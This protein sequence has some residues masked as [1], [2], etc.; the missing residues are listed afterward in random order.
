MSEKGKPLMNKTTLDMSQPQE[1]FT[2]A[3]A[4]ASMERLEM[5]RLLGSRSM[6]VKEMAKELNLPMSSAA[7]HLSILEEAGLIVSMMQPGS[8]GNVKLCS[9]CVRTLKIFFTPQGSDLQQ[10]QR[11][12]TYTLP[13]GAF[14]SV[15]D[16]TPTCG[17]G[18]KTGIIAEYDKPSLFYHPK[19]LAAQLMWFRSGFAE[20][21]FPL[22]DQGR[23]KIC[24]L[25][26]SFEANPQTASYHAPWKSDISVS[27]NGVELGTWQAE[28]DR[29]VRR[30]FLTPS[31]WA[32]INTQYGQLKT[33]RVNPNGA[34]LDSMQ[35]SGVTLEQLRLGESDAI[36]IRIGVDSHA[37]NVGG[38]VLF[39]EEAGDFPQGIT[40][41]I[42]Y[43]ALEE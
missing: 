8:R 34:F 6:N 17:M 5:L 16:I 26:L 40:L 33:W 31:W 24:W 37:E 7:M 12:E 29:S 42:G 39:G 32:N 21:R 20:Y 3:R 9:K 25:E 13:I 1:V 10:A 18:S 35:L 38:I 28:S 2:V 23:T 19:R 30:G 41:R 27:I 36:C 43:D 15:A 11:T 14:N 4:L 22:P